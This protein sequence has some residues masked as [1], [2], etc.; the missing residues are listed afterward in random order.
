MPRHIVII[1]VVAACLA[2]VVAAW[3]RGPADRAG[4]NAES[5]HE[6]GANANNPTP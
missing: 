4:Q 1:A 3:G 2:F 6:E 5:A